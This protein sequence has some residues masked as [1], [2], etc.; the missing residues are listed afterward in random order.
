MI[1]EECAQSPNLDFEA[2]LRCFGG[3]FKNRIIFARVGQRERNSIENIQKIDEN[4]SGN[5]LVGGLGRVWEPKN[6]ADGR[7]IREM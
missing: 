7:E 6:H 4:S 2:T 3:F 1:F 5:R